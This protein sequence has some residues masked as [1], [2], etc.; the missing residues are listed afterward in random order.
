MHM[1]NLL[2]V[3]YWVWSIFVELWPAQTDLEC[4]LK[5]KSCFRVGAKLLPSLGIQERRKMT[6]WLPISIFHHCHCGSWNLLPKSARINPSTPANI[7]CAI[8]S[9]EEVSLNQYMRLNFWNALKLPWNEAQI[10]CSRD[11][12]IFVEL[13][14]AQTDLECTL[15]LKSCFRVG[16]K[17]LPS[18]GIQERRKMTRRLPI[19]IFHHCHCGS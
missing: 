13:W 15:K 5:L 11:T 16:S 6:R 1:G 7:Y 3:I 19:S 10:L 12:S 17:L 9:M 18:L 4:T 2:L 14:P 8:R